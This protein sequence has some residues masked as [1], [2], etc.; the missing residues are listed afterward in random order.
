MIFSFLDL[1]IL[2]LALLLHLSSLSVFFIMIDP[3]RACSDDE[4]RV[5]VDVL[6]RSSA[7][8]I[9]C[10]LGVSLLPFPYCFLLSSL[11][12]NSCCVVSIPSL[13]CAQLDFYHTI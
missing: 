6:R 12:H 9:G 3:S 13:L 1:I 4:A 8:P 7:C 2:N 5:A 11:T 10:P